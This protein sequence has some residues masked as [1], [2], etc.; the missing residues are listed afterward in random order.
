MHY[1]QCNCIQLDTISDVVFYSS[2][3]NYW[4]CQ[5]CIWIINVKYNFRCLLSFSF[6]IVCVCV[7]GW[8]IS[9]IGSLLLLIVYTIVIAA[10]VL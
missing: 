6:I 2:K 7:R 9:D 5:T 8:S 4:Y 1:L 3:T 10:Q